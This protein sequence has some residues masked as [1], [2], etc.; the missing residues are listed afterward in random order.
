MT[1]L[2]AELTRPQ[3]A[4]SSRWIAV[5]AVA[6]L[7]VT[8]ALILLVRGSSAASSDPGAP[9]SSEL[10]GRV[11]ELDQ[12]LSAALVDR[13]RL[14]DQLV[15][16]I[17]SRDSLQQD[18]GALQDELSV[19]LEEKDQEIELLNDEVRALQKKVARSPKRTRNPRTADELQAATDIIRGDLRG[20]FGEW[21][22]RNPTGRIR[23]VVE[24]TITPAGK[25]EAASTSEV[26]DSSLPLCVRGALLRAHYPRGT[27]QRVAFEVRSAEGSNV[28]LQVLE[29]RP[30]PPTELI[31]LD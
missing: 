15:A 26:A 10:I 20:C 31:E 11:E 16:A 30:T 23:F 8:A 13:Q 7:A 21:R 29:T 4:L 28:A 14:R 27:T 2:L 18:L 3:L 9:L 1:A 22:E 5:A 19:Q 25:G 24:L 12:K 17:E 6:A